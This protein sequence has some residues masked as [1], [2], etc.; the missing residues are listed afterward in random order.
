M[1]IFRLITDASAVVQLVLLILLFFSVFSWAIIYFKRRTIKTA[2]AQSEKFLNS[3]SKLT[4]ALGKTI[5]GEVYVTDL[6]IM[7]HLLIA[8]QREPARASPCVAR[9]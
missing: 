4:F 6:S 5:H 2:F 3:P 7:P 1:N 9:G 8:A